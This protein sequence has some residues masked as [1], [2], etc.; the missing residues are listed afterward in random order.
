MRPCSATTRYPVGRFSNL[1]STS[2]RRSRATA[3]S[4]SVAA[5]GRSRAAPGTSAVG[6]LDALDLDSGSG[7]DELFE[8][9]EEALEPPGPYDPAPAHNARVP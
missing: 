6:N 5:S 9:F 4:L 1:R 7:F 3:S 2:R 8:R